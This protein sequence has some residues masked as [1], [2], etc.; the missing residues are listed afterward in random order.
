MNSSSI[1]AVSDFLIDKLRIKKLNIGNIIKLI[2]SPKDDN[3]FWCNEDGE[4]I[5]M[6][7]VVYYGENMNN[8]SKYL[9]DQSLGN[10]VFIIETELNS[11]RDI[12]S[13]ILGKVMA[14][15]KRCGFVTNFTLSEDTIKID[16]FGK[17]KEPI[18][19]YLGSKVLF[20][21]VINDPEEFN[22]LYDLFADEK[23]R[24]IQDIIQIS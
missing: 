13:I 14:V 18:I 8:S 24:R 23:T 16:T 19:S 1:I 21:I 3:D 22:R 12:S 2:R 7:K 10:S 4:I 5:I 11:R 15:E 9:K 20:F 6:E 17:F